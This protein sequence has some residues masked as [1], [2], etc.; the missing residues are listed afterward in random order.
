MGKI[1]VNADEWTLSNDGF[2]A[3][4][5][6]A[7]FANN[8]AKWF[9]GDRAGKFHAYSTN[10][11]LTQSALAETFKNA[12]HTWTTGT[13]ISFDLP[14][15]L[16]YDGIFVGAN[17]AN[18]QVLIEYV[19]AGGN[20]YVVAGTGSDAKAEADRWNPFLNAF[21]FKFLGKYNRINGNQTVNSS[22]PIFAGVK[23]LFQNNGNYIVDIDSAS[24]TNQLVLTHSSG[25]G[26]IATF[27]GTPGKVS[28]TD[29]GE[30]QEF[31]ENEKT[32]TATG[33][34][35]IADIS[36]KG[37]VKRTQSDEYVE[38]AN[39]GTTAV[40]VSGWKISSGLSKTQSFT[41]PPKTTLEAGK[42]F[43]VYT[44]E[45]NSETGGF[46]FGSSTA[47]WNDRGDEAKLFDAK[48][49]LVSTLA[50][51]VSSLAGIKTQLGIPQL[52]VKVSPSAINKQMAADSK[53][54][55]V[56]AFQLAIRSFLED[57]SD[58]ESPLSLIFD[59]IELPK[60][61][62]E[63]AATEEVRSYLNRPTSTLTLLTP[64]SQYQAEHGETVDSNWI[65]LLQ[66]EEL[67]DHLHWVII[68]RSGVKAPYNYG[69]N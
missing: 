47:I 6:A 32:G 38:I 45:V 53:V 16:T 21:G 24:P 68:D 26:L 9:A 64:K 33:T 7:I 23:A 1:V 34:V 35:A 57:G 11:G 14:T 29:E 28:T 48:G 8:I 19:K 2:K 44:N 50:Y 62:R 40:D 66:M 42:S 46:S 20:V 65:F 27:D 56:D 67:S 58:A 54:T 13:N 22:H 31:V 63:A 15:L 18:N 43:R 4:P 61:G 5:D 49:N 37:K 69:F 55:F 52:R 41:F 59:N 17:A 25:Q 39:Q 10:F 12:G 3:A 30:S 51:G 60:E 36:Y